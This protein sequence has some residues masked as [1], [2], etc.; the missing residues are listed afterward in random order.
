MP[1]SRRINLRVTEEVEE[2]LKRAAEARKM[3]LTNFLLA[4]GN[5]LADRVL[6]PEQHADPVPQVVGTTA[7]PADNYSPGANHGAARFFPN[8]GVELAWHQYKKRW[9]PAVEFEDE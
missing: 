4:A 5:A 7:A 9:M 6:T 3:S 2:R 8:L 1:G